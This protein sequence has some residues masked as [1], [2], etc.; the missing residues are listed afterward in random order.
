MSATEMATGTPIET[1]PN[2]L[3]LRIFG[4]LSMKKKIVIQEVSRRCGILYMTVDP[5]IHADNH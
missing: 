2:E 4:L 5:F 1:L 3:L